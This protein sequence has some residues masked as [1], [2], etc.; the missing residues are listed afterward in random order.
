MDFTGAD[1]TGSAFDHCNL[2]KATFENTN[3]EKADFTTA[4]HYTIDPALNKIKKAKF[5]M[6]GLP[7]LLT[8]YDIVIR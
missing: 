6:M 5:G 4:E 3:L 7:G 8:R 1:L 2:L